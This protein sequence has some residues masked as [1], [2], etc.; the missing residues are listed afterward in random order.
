M[1]K[2]FLDFYTDQHTKWL[3]PVS[4]V[5]K[6]TCGKSY[7]VFEFD[8]DTDNHIVMSAWAKH[9]RNHYCLD[10]EIDLIKDPKKS[11]SEFLLEYK[12]PHA[13]VAPGPSIRAGDF[14]EVLVADYLRFIRAYYVPSTRYDQKAIANES[15]KG[16]DILAFKF[17]A[18][19]MQDEMLVY[20]VKAALTKTDEN[21]M[22]EA[23]NHSIKDQRRMAEALQATKERL[24]HK[25]DKE[26]FL[27]LARFQ[28]SEEN[29]FVTK[30]G[31]ASVLTKVSYF[32]DHLES[33]DTQAHPGNATLELLVI[34]GK[35]FMSLAH[36]LYERA[37]NEA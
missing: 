22:Q 4:E 24:L 13:S 20:E 6:T 15:T 30:F 14:A 17:G 16:T 37:A 34:V 8:H 33:V 36:S 27:Q 1:E 11:K 28:N 2:F 9:F 12:F 19:S 23:I 21:K 18:A 25:Q 5:I 3:K 35:D 10:S 31:A 7:Q 32:V 26:G 29:P